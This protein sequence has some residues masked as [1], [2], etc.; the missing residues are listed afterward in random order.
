MDIHYINGIVF[1]FCGGFITACLLFAILAF[2][3][4][5][6][7]SKTVSEFLSSHDKLEA[8]WDGEYRELLRKL[9][10]GDIEGAKQKVCLAIA[11]FYHI[12]GSRTSSQE[13]AAEKR[14]IDIQAKSSVILAAAIEKTSEW[15]KPSP[16]HQRIES[17]GA[18]VGGP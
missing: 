9:E 2:R 15:S 18:R 7:R 13:L 8:A 17:T 10:A 1:A 4:E 12:T 11:T 5:A 3:L 16:N 14:K 6:K